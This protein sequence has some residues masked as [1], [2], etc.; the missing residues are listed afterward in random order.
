MILADTCIW[1]D[2]FRN[3]G[4]DFSHLLNQGKI[5]SHWIVIGEL[6]SGNLPQRPQTL[7]DLRNLPRIKRATERESLALIENRSLHGCGLSWNDI[8]LLASA[9]VNHTPLWTNDRRLDIIATD[10]NANYCP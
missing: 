4:S 2:F 6:A 7:A 10:L 9:L 3:G 5:A 1:I 8:Q